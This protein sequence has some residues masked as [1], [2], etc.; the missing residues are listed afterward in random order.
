LLAAGIALSSSSDVPAC[1]AGHAP[2]DSYDYDLCYQY[3]RDRYHPEQA[4]SVWSSLGREDI[5]IATNFEGY[6]ALRA[7][8]SPAIV[9]EYR[10]PPKSD[11]PFPLIVAHD[12]PEMRHMARVLGVDR[13]PYG[14]VADTGWF[15]VY[16]PGQP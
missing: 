7:L 3:F 8:G 13:V 12:D 1:R 15:K 6:H 5:P 9:F 2:R 4:L 16:A 10:V 11:F 14:R